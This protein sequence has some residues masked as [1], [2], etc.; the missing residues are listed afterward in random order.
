MKK[1]F[2]YTF[3]L[4]FMALGLTACGGA[5]ETQETPVTYSLDETSSLKWKGTYA[6]D[7][8]FHEGTVALAS[9]TM[10]YKGDVFEA[11]EFTV[12]MK[13]MTSDLTPETG[14]EKL[15]GHLASPDFFSIA[16][17]PTVNVKVNAVTD[18]EMDLTIN[19]IGKEINTKVP[20]AVKQSAKEVKA[21]GKFTLDVSSLDL[22]GFKADPA[23]EKPNQFVKPVI[24]FELNAVLKAEAK[25]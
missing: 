25:K 6:D 8:H 15:M 18:K 24:D 13:N 7:S 14:S 23:E 9:G 20:V 11:G 2:I 10:T 4:G 21:S 3:A 16:Q 17:F 12:D 1:T 22:A 5:T 19:L